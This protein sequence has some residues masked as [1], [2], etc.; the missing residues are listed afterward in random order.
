MKKNNPA[1][2]KRI[3]LEELISNGADFTNQDSKND[4]FRLESTR[5]KSMLKVKY[6]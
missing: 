3:Y 1:F 4:W 2:L 6:S 5:A